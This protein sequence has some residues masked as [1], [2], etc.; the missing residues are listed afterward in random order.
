MPVRY[1]RVADGGVISS[2]YTPEHFASRDSSSFGRTAQPTLSYGRTE[3]AY[4]SAT[5]HGGQ[6]QYATQ[7]PTVSMYRAFANPAS[8]AA[9]ERVPPRPSTLHHT[10]PQPAPPSPTS[11]MP[12]YGG[13]VASLQARFGRTYGEHTAQ[14]LRDFPAG[15][16]PSNFAATA[17][18]A[19]RY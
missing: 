16:R 18:Q 15:K 11:H 9:N 12:G 17:P 19:G 10:I 2:A 3:N 5:G 8:L 13:H 14:A 6:F 4:N 1:E 7:S